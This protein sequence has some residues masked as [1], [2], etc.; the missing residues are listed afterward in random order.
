MAFDMTP[1]QWRDFAA[2]GTRTGK[3][4]TVRA[5]GR[6]HIAPIW[7]V[8][9]GD[10]LVFNT[11][12]TSVKGKAILRDPRVAICIDDEAPPFAFVLLEGTAQ[13]STDVAEMLPWAI[14]IGARY[15][16]ADV[17]EQFGRRNAVAGELLVRVT[18]S[19]VIAKG[20]VAE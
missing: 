3:L 8:L 1:E 13:T 20:G 2:A 14:K 11:G 17:A 7:F 4:A 16:G 9:D 15:M 12:A 5:D 10:D 6:P 19:R 18:P